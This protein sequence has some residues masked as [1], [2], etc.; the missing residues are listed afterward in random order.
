MPRVNIEAERAR[1]QLTQEELSKRLGV[2]PNTYRNYVIGGPIPSTI[3][4]KL[5]AMTG[6]TIE[7]LLNLEE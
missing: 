4:E 5:R 3:Q 6:K 7:Y 2:S 1:L